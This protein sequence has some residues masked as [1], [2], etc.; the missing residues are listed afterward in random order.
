MDVVIEVRDSRIPTSTAHPLVPKWIGNRLHLVAMMRTDQ[1]SHKSLLD[2]KAYYASEYNPSKSKVYFVEGKSGR[3]IEVLRKHIARAGKVVNEKRKRMGILTKRSVRAAVIGYPNVGKSSLINRILRRK[4][5]RTR[6]IAGHTRAMQWIKISSSPR[7]STGNTGAS[8]NA[9]AKGG[10]EY[11]IEM[12]DSP[13][14]IPAKHVDQYAAMS[15]A[16]CNDIGQ[17]AYNNQHAAIALL[18]RILIISSERGGYV[19]LDNVLK[20][21]KVLY[22]D[23]L[24]GEEI[25]QS[26]AQQLCHD[27]LEQAAAKVLGD[28]RKG[29]WGNV[30]LEAPPVVPRRKSKR[31]FSQHSTFA[32]AGGDDDVGVVNSE[33][34]G[35]IYA[36][37]YDEDNNVAEGDNIESDSEIV[38][39]MSVLSTEKADEV[40]NGNEK[41]FSKNWKSTKIVTDKGPFDGW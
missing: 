11:A 18:D 41:V 28:F 7:P 8:S 15:L 33:T 9:K 35:D 21:Y 37:S 31:E 3:G 24:S 27:S 10:A 38:E 29:Y 40:Q 19:N 30:T 17:A 1:A 2:W 12:L 32:L 13:G 23:D 4:L 36:D 20:R 22:R 14:I 25:L 6:N 34:D 26:L 5:A 16:I 39:K